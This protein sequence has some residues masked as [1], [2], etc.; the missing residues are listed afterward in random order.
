MAYEKEV[1]IKGILGPIV[2]E[3]QNK[4]CFLINEDTYILLHH[5]HSSNN[6]FCSFLIYNSGIV[7]NARP[8]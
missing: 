3:I 8:I 2:K 6:S 1:L 7:G 5:L 4:P